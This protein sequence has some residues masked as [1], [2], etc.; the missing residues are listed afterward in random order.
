MNLVVVIPAYEAERHVRG[1]LSRVLGVSDL[2]I[3]R[4]VVVDD[5]S[6][7]GTRKEVEAAAAHHPRIELVVRAKNGGYGAAMKDGLEAAR[8]TDPDVVA[9]VHADGQYSPEALPSLLD[10]LQR[11]KL[12]LLQGSRIASGTALE[13]GMPFYKYVANAVLNRIENRTLD[14]AMTDYHSGYI[15]YGRRALASVPFRSLSDSF[16]FDLEVIASACARG[17]SV[18]EA[19]VPTHYGDET[20][21][22]N[23]ITYG[24]RVLHVMWKYRRGSYA[25]AALL[26]ILSLVDC[27]LR[28]SKFPGGS[29]PSK[30]P[31]ENA[32]VRTLNDGYQRL[33]SQALVREIDR[34]TRAALDYAAY[35]ANFMIA[36]AEPERPPPAGSAD[37]SNPFRAL[38]D[39]PSLTADVKTTPLTEA[40]RRQ[41]LAFAPLVQF[42]E[43]K[44]IAGAD[45]LEDLAAAVRGE[46]WGLAAIPGAPSQV[47]SE[48]YLHASPKGPAEVW[49][50]IEFQPWFKGLGKLPDQDGD[51]F[52]EV[53]G[54]VRADRFQPAILD[55]IEHDY[56]SRVLTPPEIKGWANQLSSY[57][58]PSFNTDLAPAGAAWPDDRTEADIK[59]EL[60]GRSFASPTIVLRGKPQGKP[61]YE[62]FLVKTGGDVAAP[63]PGS[64]GTLKLAK[65]RPTPD[66]Q[67]T[68][69]NIARE[70]S[71]EGRGSFEKW[72]TQLLPF[73]EA[74]GR[75]LKTTPA[76]VKAFAGADGFLFYRR[77]LEY[78]AGGD[79]EKQR[80]GKNPLPVIVEF[81]KALESHGVDFLFV[82]VPT[83]VEIFPDKL[84]PKFK[85]LAGEVV[86]PFGRKFLASLAERG[87][88]VVDLLP[89]FLDARN[90][91][92][93]PGDEPLYQPQDT[94]WTDRG[95]RL[96][97]DA[98]AAR[99]KKYPWYP[100]LAAHAQ[101]FG[102]KD[103]TFTRLGDLHSRLPEADKRKYKP[104][105]LIAHQVMRADGKPYDDDPDSPIVV[106]GDSFTGVYELTDAEHA[107]LSAHVAR[108]V[109]YP[110]DLVMSYGGGPNVR[111]KLLRRGEAALDA[112][113]LIIWVMTARDFYD[114]WENWE[115]LAA[116]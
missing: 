8:R 101:T 24:L 69:K 90:A 60:G 83:K 1:V 113:K 103:T 30:V 58:Y 111:Q 44:R 61:T 5:G 75:R 42:V 7:D 34:P 104:E 20:S 9:C 62:V 68:A 14:L 53:Y 79:I 32:H 106:L 91:G 49:A 116:P 22:L 110:I 95:M 73:D 50:K 78:V 108:G 57:W 67:T 87:V 48:I 65:T 55:A 96:A 88:E 114:H 31:S 2:E 38:I 85:S 52:P 77:S 89:I 43:S 19:P 26:A 18:G 21:H 46:S 66:W 105:T 23:P 109:S 11:K 71:V 80:P 72:A 64:A 63:A 36:D 27:Q 115:P 10:A 25:A 29:D 100:A 107:G 86:H 15:V 93:G 92:D 76:S 3:A 98:L 28:S 16:D 56:A 99:V 59:R 81:K 35:H 82:P 12:D 39:K 41:P 6:R 102:T 70:L 47:L 84:D 17:L 97:A 37:T 40:E 33:H 45:A 74:I 54:R 13:G 112:K 94:H 4:V 51:G